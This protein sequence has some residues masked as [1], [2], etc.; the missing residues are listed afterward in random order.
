MQNKLKKD[1]KND[2]RY[3]RI[4]FFQQESFESIS[5]VKDS[6]QYSV[7]WHTLCFLVK[8]HISVV[9]MGVKAPG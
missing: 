6:F 5:I 7:K 4:E 9:H 1:S 8:E 2:K 3:V